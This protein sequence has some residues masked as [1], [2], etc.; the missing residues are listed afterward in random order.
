M[1]KQSVALV[2]LS[3]GLFALP[4]AAQTGSGAGNQSPATNQGGSSGQLS[5]SASQPSSSQAQSGQFIQQSSMGQW[6]ASKLV[7]VDVY[8]PNNE[9]IGDIKEVLIDQSGNAQAVVIGVGGFLGMGEKNVALPFKSVQWSNEPRRSASGGSTSNTTGT[10]GGSGSTSSSGS[11]GTA[12]GASNSA[13]RDYPDHAMLN[14]SRDDL[15][16]APDFHY[17]S[18]NRSGSSGGTSG[19]RSG[20]GTGGTGGSTR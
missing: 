4:A 17:A 8:G 9:K 12:S 19:G 13:N 14:M 20:G 3:A 10:A 6:R 16:N 1:S 11:A 2:I 5:P 7:G 18:E 15:K